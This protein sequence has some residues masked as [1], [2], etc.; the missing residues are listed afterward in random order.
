MTKTKDLSSQFKQIRKNLYFILVEPESPGN[1]G[2]AARALKTCGFKNLVLVNPCDQMD[3]E[4]RKMAHRSLDIIEKAQ[5]FLSFKDAVSTM[6]IAAGTTMRKRDYKF[7]FYNP[8]ELADKLLPAALEKPTAVVFG[9]ERTGLT[10]EEL[11]QCHL[12]STI[13]T[14]VQNPA[15]NL[16]QA[17]MIYAHTFFLKLHK[18]QFQY[19]YEP[20]S[21]N[22]LEIFYAHLIKSL[23]N[24]NFT[25]RDGMPEFITRFRRIISRT[26]PESRDIRLLHKL[27]QIFETRISDLEKISQGDKK[28]NIF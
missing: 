17:V 26:T 23:Q 13:P 6:R 2:S 20:A 14:A 5:V 27:L 22:E 3:V 24:V 15:L 21:Q 8:D 18:E 7:P 9:R 28:R 19:T 12:H 11:L 4:A 25:P 1:I 10:N 16:A